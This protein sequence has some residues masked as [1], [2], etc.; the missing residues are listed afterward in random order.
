MSHRPSSEKSVSHGQKMRTGERSSKSNRVEQQRTSY[1]RNVNENIQEEYFTDNEP[2]EIEIP[3]PRYDPKE[4]RDAIRILSPFVRLMEDANNPYARIVAREVCKTFYRLYHPDI[5][6]KDVMKTVNWKR[7]AERTKQLWNECRFYIHGGKIKKWVSLRESNFIDFN[8]LNQALIEKEDCGPLDSC[9]HQPAG[10]DPIFCEHESKSIT[11]QKHISPAVTRISTEKKKNYASEFNTQQICEKISDS[12]RQLEKLVEATSKKYSSMPM[13]NIEESDKISNRTPE[14]VCI[15]RQTAGNDTI[16]PHCES[17]RN[18]ES[19]YD[20]RDNLL[21]N[22]YYRK[23]ADSLRTPRRKQNDLKSLPKTPVEPELRINARDNNECRENCVKDLDSARKSTKSTMDITQVTSDAT[24]IAESF[25]NLSLAKTELRKKKA[26]FRKLTEKYLK[27][28][29]NP[30]EVTPPAYSDTPNTRMMMKEIYKNAPKLKIKFDDDEF[31]DNCFKDRDFIRIL[32]FYEIVHNELEYISKTQREYGVN[33]LDDIMSTF[34]HI[35]YDLGDPRLKSYLVLEHVKL[36]THNTWELYFYKGNKKIP[37]IPEPPQFRSPPSPTEMPQQHD[38]RPPIY[39]QPVE[40]TSPV[41]ESSQ[42]TTNSPKVHRKR[43][44]MS[45]CCSRQ[46]EV[47]QDF[48]IKRKF[49]RRSQ[50][51]LNFGVSPKTWSPNLKPI[52]RPRD[53]KEF[54]AKPLPKFIRDRLN[55]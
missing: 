20:Y 54:K 25:A 47:P 34:Y 36:I 24:L 13:N 11:Q 18:T 32:P 22:E 44:G 39:E 35:H 30:L 37:P 31:N 33:M 48:P 42:P 50:T 3:E 52:E 9:E 16:L 17:G 8:D 4:L 38:I 53:L 23:T 14:H 7:K 1:S 26:A 27:F 5:H 46:D 12:K 19:P 28:S 51:S 45:S 40:K 6:P 15:I 21:Q 2:Q 49:L 43:H 55:E 41:P 10:H 29:S